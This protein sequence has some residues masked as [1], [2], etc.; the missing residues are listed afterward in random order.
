MLHCLAK[1][2]FAFLAVLA[3]VDTFVSASSIHDS[4]Q[5]RRQHRS[6]SRLNQENTT[7]VELFPRG[8]NSRWTWYNTETGNQGAC[9][10]YIMNWENAVAWPLRDFRPKEHCNKKLTL[11]FEGRTEIVT[12]R[13]ACEICPY[14][15]LDLSKGLFQRIAPHGDGV[16]QGTWTWGDNGGGEKPPPPKTT[17]KKPPPPKTTSTTARPKPTSTKATSTSTSSTHSTTSKTSTSV[18]S[19]STTYTSTSISA[20]PTNGT[21][22][23]GNIA[24]VNDVFVRLGQFVIASD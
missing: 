15:G 23:G 2:A 17:T 5:Q 11:T 7:E 9:G 24:A 22:F 1:G 6:L 4:R 14:G 20:L 8:A 3:L 12:I 16:V 10:G 19:T 13:D 18:T 21:S